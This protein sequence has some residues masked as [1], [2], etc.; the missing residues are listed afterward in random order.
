MVDKSVQL[1]NRIV[2]YIKNSMPITTDNGL[3][4]TINNIKVDIPE[5]NY[6]IDNQLNMKYSGNG[7]TEGYIGGS[8]KITNRAGSKVYGPAHYKHLVTFPVATERGTYIVNG[9][10]KNIISQMRMKSGCYTNNTDNANNTNNTNATNPY[11]SKEYN[12]PNFNPYMQQSQVPPVQKKK[13]SGTLETG[14]TK[15]MYSQ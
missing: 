12:S 3:E 7:N 5:S 4:L 9:V 11:Y 6:D 10:E 14:N 2:E 13:K 8:I 15:V 1:A